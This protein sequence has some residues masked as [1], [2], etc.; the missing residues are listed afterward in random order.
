[1]K[2][3]VVLGIA[4]VLVCMTLYEWPR[5]KRWMK[6]EKN[7][8]AALTV[9]GGI[10]ACLL[11]FYPETPGPT[12]FIDAVYKPLVNIVEKLTMERSG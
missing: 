10:L 7:A 12:Q 4:A 5:M 8:F 1:M 2:W 6:R 11:V 3:A 9:L